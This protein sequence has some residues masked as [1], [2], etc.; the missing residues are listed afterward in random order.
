MFF[1][2]WLIKA[3]GCTLPIGGILGLIKPGSLND[4]KTKKPITKATK[5]PM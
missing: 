3:K 4:R 2:S 5:K 1:P